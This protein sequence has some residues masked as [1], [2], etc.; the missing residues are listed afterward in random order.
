VHVH[1]VGSVYIAV[2]T[3]VITS[4]V[5]AGVCSMVPAVSDNAN[6]MKRAVHLRVEASYTNN[7]YGC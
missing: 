2:R 3:V 4:V 6:T 7:A 5:A 1:D